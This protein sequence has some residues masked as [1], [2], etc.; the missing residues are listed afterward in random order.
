MPKNSDKKA[1]GDTELENSIP[2]QIAKES[3]SMTPLKT[4]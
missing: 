1:P 3:M 4:F 2:K